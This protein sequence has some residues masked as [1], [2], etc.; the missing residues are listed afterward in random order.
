MLAAGTKIEQISV[1]TPRKIAVSLKLDRFGA[2][3][4]HYPFAFALPQDIH[5]DILI[6]HLLRGGVRVER[7]KAFRQL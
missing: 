4:S 6:A 7:G 1:R 5:E 2:G 3:L